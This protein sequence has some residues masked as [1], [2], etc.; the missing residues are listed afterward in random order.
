MSNAK[1]AV[2]AGNRTRPGG[3]PSPAPAARAQ[4]APLP[5]IAAT[6]TAGGTRT[7]AQM[8]F[9][10]EPGCCPPQ[11]HERR[12]SRRWPAVSDDAVGRLREPATWVTAGVLP[13]TAQLE[14]YAAATDPGGRHPRL[15]LDHGLAVHRAS[16]DWAE[17]T[18][19]ALSAAPPRP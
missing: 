19:A 13:F 10:D 5:P 6:G 11:H 3:V 4:G 17:R 1:A 15:A 9:Q 2:A 7:A 12:L 16:L 8:A 14:Q 18:I